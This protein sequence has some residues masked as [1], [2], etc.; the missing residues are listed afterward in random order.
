MCSVLVDAP[1][2]RDVLRSRLAEKGIETRPF[3]CPIHLMPMYCKG[4]K[5]FPV[6]EDLALRG[7]N[8]P[9]YPKLT[10]EQVHFIASV[11]IRKIKLL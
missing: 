6:A 8:L 4:N 5:H 9:S 3:F 10:K 7:I 2:K 11:I 1:Y